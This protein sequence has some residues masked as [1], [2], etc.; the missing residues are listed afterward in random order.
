V[1]Q[2]LLTRNPSTD[3]RVY[4]VWFNMYPGDARWRWDGDAM[5]DP[6]VTHFWDEQKL[7]G[8]WFSAQLTDEPEPTWDYYAVYGPTERSLERP[9]GSG[10]SIIGRRDDLEASVRAALAAS[11]MQPPMGG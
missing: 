2:E 7:V 8:S 3:L 6:R 5:V 11:A 10:G 9:L 1:Q 4:A